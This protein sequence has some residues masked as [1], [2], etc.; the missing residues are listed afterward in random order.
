MSKSVLRLPATKVK[1]QLSRSTINRLEAEGKFPRRIMLGDGR[2]VGW[3]EEEIDA[4]LASRPRVVA[5]P[6]AA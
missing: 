5:A 1:T 6:K 4:W 2:A 3:F